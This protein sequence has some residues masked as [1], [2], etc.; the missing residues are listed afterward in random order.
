MNGNQGQLA[1]TEEN[2]FSGNSS[3]MATLHALA[4]EEEHDYGVKEDGCVP[5]YKLNELSLNETHTSGVEI[6]VPSFFTMPE[7][8]KL[9]FPLASTA[10]TMEKGE[11]TIVSVNLDSESPSDSLRIIDEHRDVLRLRAAL[12]DLLDKT[13]FRQVNVELVRENESL[14]SIDFEQ[15]DQI[16]SHLIYNKTIRSNKPL[17]QKLYKLK[18]IEELVNTSMNIDENKV[19]FDDFIS[20]IKTLILA[21]E[22]YVKNEILM[23]IEHINEATQQ[24][25]QSDIQELNNRINTLKTYEKQC[26]DLSVKLA[27]YETLCDNDIFEDCESK[28]AIL[29]KMKSLF[30]FEELSRW[31]IF[32]DCINP[33][34]IIEKIKSIFAKDDAV[35]SFLNK[36]HELKGFED[37][38]MEQILEKTQDLIKQN[39]LYEELADENTKLNNQAN[40]E[41]KA[42]KEEISELNDQILLLNKKSQI[43]DEKVEPAPQK[44]VILDEIEEDDERPLSEELSQSLPHKKMTVMKKIG[45]GF[46]AFVGVIVLYFVGISFLPVKEEQTLTT[47]KEF[48]NAIKPIA[49]EVKNTPASITETPVVEQTPPAIE[50][51]KIPAAVSAIVD[52]TPVGYD[53]NAVLSEDVFK[54]QKF[55]IYVDDPRKVRINGKNFVSGE[56]VNGFKFIRT[57]NSGKILFMNEA[58]GKSLWLTMN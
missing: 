44:D 6:T 34:E 28:D 36:F 37:L 38:S 33:S 57:V 14:K 43:S 7:V 56:S 52:P 1:T 45:I 9:N 51:N 17:M 20:Q 10:E 54:K 4:N 42:L 49:P 30:L 31:D 39:A 35:D 47:K 12:V 2:I 46:G 25:N 21:Y 58:D 40:K 27:E 24:K 26:S 8:K 32:D 41:I 15:L 13:D 50:E 18:D 16:I 23:Q 29:E 5:L 11:E 53:F 3:S 22:Q 48:S 55:D 19:K